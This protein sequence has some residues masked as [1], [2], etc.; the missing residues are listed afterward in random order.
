MS[1]VYA[2]PFFRVM[3]VFADFLWFVSLA[4]AVWILMFPVIMFVRSGE[5]V[6]PIIKY[7]QE[8][9][10]QL[11]LSI[12]VVLLA[13][14]SIIA[15]VYSLRGL[16]KSFAKSVFFEKAHVWRTRIIG[17]AIVMLAS[18]PHLMTMIDSGKLHLRPGTYLLFLLGTVVAALGE[19]FRHGCSLQ[20][21]Q[22]LTV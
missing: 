19:V 17:I 4:I 7:P 1:S 11:V 9:P 15:I 14:G 16:F 13:M 2:H 12:G 6:F 8:S 22:D 10:V 20:E 3:K 18:A 21:E 5:P